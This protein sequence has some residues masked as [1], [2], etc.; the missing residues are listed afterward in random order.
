MRGPSLV[1]RL[2]SAARY[3]F[4]RNKVENEIDAELRYHYERLI[5]EN[6]RTGMT[7]AEARAVAARM[8]GG[9]EQIKEECRDARLGRA[10]ESTLQDVRY[11][12]RTLRKNPGITAMAILTLALGIGVNT[13]VFSV[14]YGILLR[15]LPYQRGG[16][17]IVLHQQ[18][19]QMHVPDFP[20][21]AQEVFDYRDQNH[22]LDGVVE[23]HTMTFLLM[24]KESAERV[25]TAVVSANFF[26]VLGVKPLLGRTFVA[27][28]EAHGADAV[29]VL[30]NK[31]WRTRHSADPNIVGR[32]FQMNNRPHTVIGVL[33]PIPQYPVESDV[34]MPTSQCPTRSS[35]DFIKNRQS[36][37]MTVFGRLKPGVPLEQAQADLSV[38]AKHLER[39]YPDAYPKEAGYAIAAAPLR[40]DLTRRGRPTF[41][42]LLGAAALVLLIACANVGN[43][44]LA[45]LLRVER[46]LAVRAALGASRIR[47]VRQLLAES[48]LLA[49]AGAAAGLALAPPTVRLLATFAGRFTTRADEVKI[50]APVLLFTLALSIGTA[51]LFGLAPAFASSRNAGEA[52]KLATG[53]TT[54]SRGRQRLRAVLVLAQVA[55]SFMLLIGAGLMLRSFLKLEQVNPGFRTEHLLAVRLTPNFSHYTARP[56]LLSLWKSLLDRVQVL[57]GVQSVALA[58]NYPF[59]PAGIAGGPNTNEFQIKERPRAKGDAAPLLDANVVA[60]TYFDTIRQPVLEGRAFTDHDDSNSERVAVVNQ[61]LARHRWVS[62]NP[63]GQHVSLDQGRTWVKI[64]GIVGDVR[65][66]GLDRPASDELYIPLLQDQFANRLIIRTSLDPMHVWPLI[67]SAIRQ[68]DPY[69]A[70]DQVN[71]VDRLREESVTPPR[72]T[73]MLLALFAGLALIVSASGIAAVMALSVSQR[74]NELGI[75]MALGA[76]RR[77]VLTMIVR[78]G[79]LLA[80][81]GT[82]VG[83]AGAVA[84]TRLLAS[85]LYATSPTDAIT[86]AAVCLLFLLVSVIASLIP[87][88]RVTGI[89][90]CR[91]LRQE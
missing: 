10:I 88:R 50:D 46:E 35:A 4:R 8:I 48:L 72:V 20:F 91:A 39:S 2:R 32:V 68:I 61:S 38:I 1:H 73:T 15:P 63:I 3:L 62:V 79:V 59:N 28:D 77:S 87:A 13:A 67:R 29:L 58:T 64:V 25:D 41:L 21:S 33:P 84:M 85:L 17:L 52:L 19:L 31:Y 6:I 16:Q 57:G 81:G 56:Q 5:E 49:L 24:S 9:V 34:Y 60:S 23:H 12:I 36:R 26:D 40:D 54:S 82:M 76:P 89:D 51:L 44:L 86:F 80:I 14:V 53:R 43:L 66:Y 55:V 70:I 18:A 45:R 47:L 65:E 22:T 83:I 75:R 7:T 69:L 37:M 90:P 71:T 27:S 78:Q 30:S 74:T 42:V 11:G